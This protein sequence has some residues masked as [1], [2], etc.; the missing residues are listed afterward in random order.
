MRLLKKILQ[1]PRKEELVP[2][3]NGMKRSKEPPPKPNPIPYRTTI[4]MGRI[5]AHNIAASN[6]S[7]DVCLGPIPKGSSFYKVHKNIIRNR[8]KM[9]VTIICCS[10]CK[11]L[12]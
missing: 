7:C 3:L 6:R 4:K 2:N 1:R 5:T 11:N 12:V 8:D 10:H 9:R